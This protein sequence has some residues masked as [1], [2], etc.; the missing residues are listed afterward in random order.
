MN[1]NKNGRNKSSI[2]FTTLNRVVD[3]TKAFVSGNKTRYKHLFMVF[4][5]HY[6]MRSSREAGQEQR[7]INFSHNNFFE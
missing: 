6:L 5:I 4:T 7:E 2:L 3:F 1:I